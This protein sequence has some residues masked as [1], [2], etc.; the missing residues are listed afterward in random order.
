MKFMGRLR[1]HELPTV[2]LK[3]VGAIFRE[4]LRREEL[5]SLCE[6]LRDMNFRRN[7]IVHGE[8]WFDLLRDHDAPMDRCLRIRD[9]DREDGIVHDE[10][11]TPEVL[12]EMAKEY[13]ELSSDLDMLAGVAAWVDWR[14]DRHR[15]E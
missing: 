5:T 8:W 2:I 14:C 15:P 7:R 1:S 6:R 10:T 12:R 3:E 9:W 11:I 4:E 13:S